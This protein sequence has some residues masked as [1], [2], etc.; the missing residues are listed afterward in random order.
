M[1]KRTRRRKQLMRRL[2]EE[3]DRARRE[4]ED[5]Y[6]K[7][8]AEQLDP[9]LPPP[10]PS[11]PSQGVLDTTQLTKDDDDNIIENSVHRPESLRFFVI[12]EKNYSQ[13]IPLLHKAINFDTFPGVWEVTRLDDY[14][15]QRN[16]AAPRY[17]VFIIH[18]QGVL[19]LTPIFVYRN[20]LNDPLTNPINVFT[21][22][23]E[24]VC[25]KGMM[26]KSSCLLP[27]GAQEAV[28]ATMK[29]WEQYRVERKG[30]KSL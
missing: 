4:V 19:G 25:R 21:P 26:I 3:A 30:S 27:F 6:A 16:P 28:T 15:I 17:Y 20:Y 11:T 29:L 13:W 10:V 12:H 14:K 24:A 1:S 2:R 8:F 5:E 22:L 23:H 7:L 18:H 9:D